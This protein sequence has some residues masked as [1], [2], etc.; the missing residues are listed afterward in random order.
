MRFIPHE[1]ALGGV[2]F[3]PLFI[4]WILAII[5]SM[6]TVYLLNKYDLAKYFFYTPIVFIAF[7]IIYTIFFSL[8][9]IP[10]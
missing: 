5:V 6:L 2:Y 4:A 8:F 10:G 3:P 9:V 1:F 7:N